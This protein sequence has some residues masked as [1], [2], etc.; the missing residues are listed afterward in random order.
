[1]SRRGHRPVPFLAF[2]HGPVPATRVHWH[3]GNTNSETHNALRR[4]TNRMF[5]YHPHVRMVDQPHRTTR[6]VRVRPRI[7][8]MLTERVLWFDRFAVAMARRERCDITGIV[9]TP[10]G[11]GLHSEHC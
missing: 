3:S 10:V 1:M 7:M 6:Q 4:A 8:P 5:P 11:T 2:Q 9:A